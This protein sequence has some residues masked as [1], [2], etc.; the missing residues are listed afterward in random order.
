[1]TSEKGFGNTRNSSLESFPPSVFQIDPTVSMPNLTTHVG[2]D[3]KD[4]SPTNPA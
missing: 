1:M 3:L 4:L 2:K